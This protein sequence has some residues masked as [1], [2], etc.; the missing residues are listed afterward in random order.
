MLHGF[1]GGARIYA[2][3]AKEGERHIAPPRLRRGATRTTGGDEE[4]S[5]H[6]VREKYVS[7]KLKIL[8]IGFF[9]QNWPFETSL[10]SSQQTIS[11]KVNIPFLNT[12]RISCLF[13]PH[14]F[15]TSH[16]KILKRCYNPQVTKAL[17]T[18]VDTSEAIRLLS[19]N[20]S[21]AP[22]LRW[23][24]NAPRIPMGPIVLP[25]TDGPHYKFNEWLAGLIDGDG[26]L[27]LSK[28][29][30]ASLEITMGIRDE[31]CLN[32]IKNKYGGSIKLRSNSNALRY[33][34]HHKDGLLKLI[35]DVNGLIRNPTRMI[36]L[37]KICDKYNKVFLFPSK[38]TFE[39]GWFSGFFDADGTISINFTNAQ[40]SISASQKTTQ[41]L[42]PLV[43]IFGGK[44][45]IDRNKYESFKWYITKKSLIYSLIEYFKKY[46]SRSGKK[47]RLHLIP[48]FY[49]LK[50]LNAH[51]TSKPSKLNKSWEIFCDKWF[52]FES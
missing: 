28:Q 3:D 36:Q 13:I 42:E 38:L 1:L 41:I 37:N 52:K 4:H 11:G 19:S 14:F 51:K 5:G 32:Q 9:G 12:S 27:L 49:E 18:Q 7:V 26:C 15:N 45:Y 48:K 39:N 43:E 29:G 31:H 46:P 17:S 16:V 33:R 2:R 50:D 47:N 21:A 25:N 30:Y 10:I 24:A 8:R 6:A 22:H 34:L 23:G 44:I 20:D 35:D 40:L